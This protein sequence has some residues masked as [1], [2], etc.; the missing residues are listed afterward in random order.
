MILGLEFNL[1]TVA[2]LLM[3]RMG[4]A[5]SVE[6]RHVRLPCRQPAR[7]LGRLRRVHGL[8]RRGAHGRRHGQGCVRQI[9]E[10]PI[11]LRHAKCDQEEGPA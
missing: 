9:G 7:L 4:R 8:Q 1:P 11:R 3:G 10:P 5:P 6:P 2:V